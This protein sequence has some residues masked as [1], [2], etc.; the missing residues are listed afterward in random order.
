M[1]AEI[2]CYG[3]YGISWSHINSYLY[4]PDNSL[5]EWGDQGDINILADY[6]AATLWTVYLSDH[7]GGPAILSRYVQAG[8]PG[9]EGI[10][11]A[12]EYLGYKE[13]FNDVYHDWR[14]AN[15]IHT[16]LI[17]DGRYNY[18]TIDLGKPPAITATTYTISGLPVPWT[19]GTDFGT[20]KTILG[21]DTGV[22][23]LG[24]YGSDYIVLNG[25]DMMGIIQFDGD[26][27]ALYGWRMTTEGWW[28]G[29]D[30]L[31]NTLL[32][33]EAYI[34]PSNPTLE[35][36]T[37]YDI[38]EGWDFGFVQVSTDGGAT[39]VSLSN[40]YTTYDHDPAAH[41]D[42]VANL[43]GLTGK[44][45]RWP[46]W[47]TMTFDLSA[48]AGE[49]VLIGFRYM[50]DWATLGAG[51][52]ISEAKVSGTTITLTPIYPEADFMVSV[53]RVY[54][55]DGVIKYIVNDV[56][57][58]DLSEIGT[59]GA[60]ILEP[61]YVILIVSSVSQK[62]WV[63]YKFKATPPMWPSISNKLVHLCD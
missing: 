30:N 46:E 62:G 27:T 45:P 37:K 8:I 61:N 51:W 32:Y 53:V 14:I 25:W 4:T 31:M 21:Y 54:V 19:R 3:S 35:I 58:E 40:P 33:G 63:D 52:Y 5:T 55:E 10:N 15:L 43:P 20:T 28:S 26:D 41:P 42:I 22:A 48:Y 1:F 2:L 50:T 57:L 29:A 11:A 17:A 16:D 34:N 12:L 36:T 44:S 23:M 59:K 6:G 47:L 9:I 38:E 7:Y 24:P 39:W 13:R 18:K 49:T 56:K 60:Y